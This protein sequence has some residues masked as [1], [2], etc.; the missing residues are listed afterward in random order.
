VPPAR[1]HPNWFE[2]QWYRWSVHL[3]TVG[4]G[5]LFLPPYRRILISCANIICARARGRLFLRSKS[6]CPPQQPFQVSRELWLLLE[7]QRHTYRTE[8]NLESVVCASAHQG[9]RSSRRVTIILQSYC[10]S[11]RRSC[12]NCSFSQ[13]KRL[14][15]VVH[16]EYESFGTP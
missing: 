8:T 6:H 3:Y 15:S 16:H 13:S 2:R 11:H 9:S 1:H 4:I 7:Q 14:C 12:S 5:Y 10:L